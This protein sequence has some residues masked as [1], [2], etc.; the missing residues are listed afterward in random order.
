METGI[1]PPPTPWDAYQRALF[2][3]AG[4]GGAAVFLRSGVANGETPQLTLD[5]GLLTPTDY[6]WFL[7]K[8]MTQGLAENLG[9]FFFA[10]AS[11]MN[12]ELSVASVQDPASGLDVRVLSS[13][14]SRVELQIEIDDGG[15]NF[16]TSRVALTRAADEVRVLE[17]ATCEQPQPIPPMDW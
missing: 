17:A 1:M 14:D 15:V 12:P 8:P 3:L 4:Y 13:T 2:R 5:V 10:C 7:R 16:Q 6:V 9:H 11:D